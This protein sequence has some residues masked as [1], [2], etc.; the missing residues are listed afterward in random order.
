MGDIRLADYPARLGDKQMVV[1]DHT[2]PA[3][4]VSGGETIGNLNTQTG[5]ATQGLSGLD[6]VDIMDISVSGNYEI[7]SQPTGTGSRKTCK[8]LWFFS[9]VNGQGV[10]ATQN[11]AGSGMTVGNVGTIAFSG[12][13]STV[14]ASGTFKVLTA[15]T[16]TITITNPGVYTVA[17][18]SATV[19]GTGGTPPT[20]NTPTLVSILA[21]VNA[22]ANLSGE[23]VRLRYQ[24]R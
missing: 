12:G 8:L 19:T 1:V 4:Y 15:T 6:F 11:V 9:G 24:G 21:Q 22:G 10:T 5:I 14:T 7:A 17:P 2:G 23:T 3:S 16:G 20:M 18:T 13:T